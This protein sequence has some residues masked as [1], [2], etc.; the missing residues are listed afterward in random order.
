[1]VPSR[2]RLQLDQARRIVPRVFESHLPHHAPYRDRRLA[3][4]VLVDYLPRHIPW[5]PTV[6]RSIDLDT[7]PQALGSFGS[8]GRF[9]RFLNIAV[10]DGGVYTKKNK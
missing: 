1:M 6:V 4:Q 9:Y 10:H 5:T 2:F 7:N 8:D 3:V